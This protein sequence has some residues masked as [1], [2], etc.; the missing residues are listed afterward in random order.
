MVKTWALTAFA[1]T[2]LLLGV[3]GGASADWDRHRSGGPAYRDSARVY[4]VRWNDR[5]NQYRSVERERALARDDWRDRRELREARELRRERIERERERAHL[6]A[7]R[8]RLRAEQARE[9][10]RDLRD[11]DRRDR[12]YYYR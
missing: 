9:E 7:E 12:G 3:V 1:A 4:P 5:D 6:R 8:A 2:G 10:R 11:R